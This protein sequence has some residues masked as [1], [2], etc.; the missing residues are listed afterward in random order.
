[1]IEKKE[2]GSMSPMRAHTPEDKKVERAMIVGDV[3]A[4]GMQVR[5]TRR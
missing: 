5:V 4:T 1:M 3:S 2:K